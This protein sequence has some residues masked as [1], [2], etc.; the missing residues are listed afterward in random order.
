MSDL[1]SIIVKINPSY[2]FFGLVGEP[3]PHKQHPNQQGG[4][5]LY[6]S[7]INLE[8]GEECFKKLYRNNKGLH[9][10]H[11]GYSS[12]YLKDMS[13]WATVYPFQVVI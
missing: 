12:T 7:V 9:F 3:A 1:K 4:L 11:S 8:T 10:K 6:V 5:D 2:P 13:A